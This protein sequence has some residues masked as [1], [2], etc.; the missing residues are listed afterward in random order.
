MAQI[1]ASR[2]IAVNSLG[3]VKTAAQMV[4]IPLLLFHDTLP[5]GIDCKVLGDVL[6]IIAAALTVVS[7]LYYVYLAW[8]QI[9]EK[10]GS[11]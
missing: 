1:G 7:M 9:S 8:P 10:S 2:K 5:G 6:I 11:T 4:A 3:K